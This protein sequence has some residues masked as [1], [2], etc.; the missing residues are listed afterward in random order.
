MLSEKGICPCMIAWRGQQLDQGVNEACGRPD[1]LVEGGMPQYAMANKQICK[2][3]PNHCTMKYAHPSCNENVQPQIGNAK[4]DHVS[5]H[6]VWQNRTNWWIRTMMTSVRNLRSKQINTQ[7]D[8][9]QNENIVT[10]KSTICQALPS[11]KMLNLKSK[12]CMTTQP[13]WSRTD[14]RLLLIEIGMRSCVTVGCVG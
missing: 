14:L 9:Y 1:A 4:Q 10:N 2:M 6:H 13:R 8:N 11:W 12:R 7:H 3:P 5:W